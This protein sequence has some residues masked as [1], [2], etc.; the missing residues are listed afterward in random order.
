[1]V[2]SPTKQM[3][4]RM[5]AILIIMILPVITVG[6]SL[7]NITVFKGDDY[8]Q[9]A[10]EQQLYD[11]RITAERGNIYDCKMNLLAT[12]APVWTVF[13]TPNA[14]N[15]IKDDQEKSEVKSLIINE[16]SEVLDLEKE[17]IA[18]DL[19]KT[20]TYYVAI[21]KKV[22]KEEADKVRAFIKKYE[23]L[24]MSTYI[25]LDEST[26]RYYSND[27]LAST[28]LG[29]VGDD[30]QGLSGLELWY[31]EE[32]TGTPGRIVSAKNAHG[33]AMTFTYEK[34]VDQKPGNSL[35]STIDSYIQYVT[36]KYLS[37][38]VKS[39]KAL[40]RGAAIVMNVK[41]GEIKAMAVKG[42]FNPNE[43]FTLSKSDQKKV[44]KKE[45]DERKELLADLRNRQWR[46]KT[47]S[48]PYEPGSVFKVITEAIALEEGLTNR[49]NTF[50]CTGTIFVAGQKY[51]CHKKGGH[52]VQNLSEATQ[53]SCNPFFIS[54]GQT[55]G[56]NTFTKYFDAFGLTQKT[57]VDL[58]G[59]SASQYYTADKMGPVEL[60]SASFGQTF[61]ITPIQLITA[62][63]ATVNGGYLV[64]PHVVKKI[65]DNEQNVVKNF[66]TKI[67]RQ[68]ISKETSKTICEILDEVVSIGGGKNAYVAGYK[69]GGKTGTSQ[70]IDK[71]NDTGK[72]GLYVA[73]FAGFAPM[74]DPE[75]AVL[76]IVDEPSAGEYYGGNICAPVGGQI[77]ADVLPYL[78]Y[79]PKYTSEQLKS[80]AITVPNV[81]GKTLDEAK[82][83]LAKASLNYRIIGSGTK[84]TKQ[85]PGNTQSIYKNGVVILYTDKNPK[86]EKTEVPNLVGLTMSQVNSVATN[87]GLNVTFKGN[88]LS[89][90][91]VVSY[92]Q[93]ITKGTKVN[94]GSVV[95][96]YFRSTESGDI[97][98]ID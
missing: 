69:I 39:N 59:E 81:V 63:S 55:I 34:K 66:D 35:V 71:M 13:V 31:D 64:E 67:K 30:N 80:L 79:E 61:K 2:K 86:I 33:N 76:I 19:E 7:V 3:L 4:N 15:L 21:K 10:T 25:G 54:L 9:K 72:S 43:P 45:G 37:A 47:V 91:V 1:M 84:V 32:L 49:K 65:I 14:L 12:S 98:Y 48:D 40:E 42:D 26:K 17:E 18:Q 51:H 75:L 78:G 60:G 28:V 62:L 36:E 97:G 70:K 95:E 41:T 57:G 88:T 53:T 83:T 5:L 94:K 56:V 44:D 50:N 74:D 82:S 23:D 92:S 24:S 73:S 68:V 90:V 20:S 27:Y 22:E 77:F 46:N 16:L 29:F 38:A 8:Q 58:P 93:S 6:A 96:V 52:G 89:N 87:A 11:A 85:L